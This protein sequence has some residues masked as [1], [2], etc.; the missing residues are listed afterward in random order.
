MTNIKQLFDLNSCHVEQAL[1]PEYRYNTLTCKA[2]LKKQQQ[3]QQTLNCLSCER[4]RVIGLESV[5]MTAMICRGIYRWDFCTEL[6]HQS[7]N[8]HKIQKIL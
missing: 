8:H 2:T 1:A 6:G 4:V 5:L 3:Q 7:T